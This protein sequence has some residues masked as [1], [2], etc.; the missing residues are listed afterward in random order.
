MSL[1][2]TYIKPEWNDRIKNYK[3]SG[4][5]HSIVYNNFFSPLCDRL[6]NLFPEFVAPNVITLSGFIFVL[7]SFISIHSYAGNN[8]QGD[9][10]AHISFLGG[11]AY[12]VYNILDNIDGK[13]ARRTGNSS[14]LGML[15]DHGCDSFVVALTTMSLTSVCKMGDSG[16]NYLLIYSL[17]SIPFYLAIWEQYQTGILE[18]PQ[19]NGVDEG[20]LVFVF[21]YWITAFFGQNFW[22]TE[23]NIGSIKIP[24][25]RLSLYL[26]ISCSLVFCIISIKNV[27]KYHEA[28]NLK[29]NPSNRNNANAIPH[30]NSLE[31]VKTDDIFLDYFQIIY[32]LLPFLFFN[33]SLFICVLSASDDSIVSRSPKF[34][35]LIYSFMFSKL[36][37]HIMMAHITKSEFEQ[38]RISIIT[39]C[40][41]LPTISILSNHYSEYQKNFDTVFVIYFFKN[42]AL[43]INFARKLAI[44]LSN[45]LGIR[46]FFVK[47][48]I[49]DKGYSK[50]STKEVK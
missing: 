25:N 44:E 9:V 43:W 35:I 45:V 5:N 10:P 24:L 41:I 27:I 36:L 47:E 46:V 16:L 28:V 49:C 26:T 4:I 13:Q 32:S 14:P 7:L 31:I 21:L 1:Y 17:A 37:L 50:I 2:R 23:I 3:Y 48:K 19:F 11:L 6:V 12:L 30:E 42:L 18:L 29:A 22:L 33:I 15:F 40:I 8:G 34:I 38:W 39:C 20:A